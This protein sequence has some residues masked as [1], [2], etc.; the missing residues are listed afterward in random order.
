MDRERTRTG[1][2]NPSH[3]IY[4]VRLLF[5]GFLAVRESKGNPEML[6]GVRFGSLG[7]FA[8][9][10]P[11]EHELSLL[12]WPNHLNRNES[13]SKMLP[14]KNPNKEHGFRPRNFPG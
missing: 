7:R 9:L 4:D 13:L 10:E 2:K 8:P 14:R 6:A 3:T 5:P 12:V 11:I 1:L